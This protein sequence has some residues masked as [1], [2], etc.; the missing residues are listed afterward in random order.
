MRTLRACSIW[1]IPEISLFLSLSLSLSLSLISLSNLSLSLKSL[2]C[3]QRRCYP[4]GLVLTKLQRYLSLYSFIEYKKLTPPPPPGTDLDSS[5]L[6]VSLFH[7]LSLFSVCIPPAHR[8]CA[9]TSQK[10]A[11]SGAPPP[12]PLP[13]YSHTSSPPLLTYTHTSNYIFGGAVLC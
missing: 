10:Y 3:A 13:T 5:S 9:H 12:P 8:R 6:S 11:M 2:S 7:S 1:H 4:T